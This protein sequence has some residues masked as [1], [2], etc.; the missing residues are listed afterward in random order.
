MSKPKNLWRC[1]AFDAVL[2]PVTIS[3]ALLGLPC[4]LSYCG[5]RWLSDR[6]VRLVMF[7]VHNVLGIRSDFRPKNPIAPGRGRILAVKHQ[8]AWETL[9]LRYYYP[10]AVGVAKQVLFWL[11]FGWYMW[12]LGYIPIDRGGGAK[13][14]QKMMRT[15]R[16][17]LDAGI[18]VIVYP[19]GTRRLVGAPPVYKIG[20]YG[21]YRYCAAEILPIA[22]DS[23]KT[24][25]KR[26]LH[27]AAGEVQVLEGKPIAQG[28]DKAAFMHELERRIEDGCALIARSS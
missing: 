19:E 20:I 15:V 23:G 21:L 4:L 22:H 7:L 14:L 8:S 27:R 11:P 16:Q 2:Y 17:R 28:L 18:D 25:G 24:W 26:P 5:T 1:L 13:A 3:L 9:A 10:N 12:R 6:Y